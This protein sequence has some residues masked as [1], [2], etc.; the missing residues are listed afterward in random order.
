MARRHDSLVPLSRDHREALG[1]A[2]RLAHPAPP[3]PV[4][5]TTPASTP[6][7]RA[8]ETL[9]FFVASLVP[10]FAAEE[11]ALFPGVRRHLARDAP[12]QALLDGLIADHRRLETLRDRLAAAE[13][14][15]ARE[16]LLAEFGE[17]LEQHVRREERELFVR[18][19]ELTHDEEERAAIGAAIRVCLGARAVSCRPS[20]V[21]GR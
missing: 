17:L 12:E 5:P 8:R 16:R 6:A 20:D 9:G 4:T 3:G 7:H 10:H 11:T 21:P 1:L 15:G 18:F 13:A 2:F 19:P 14:D